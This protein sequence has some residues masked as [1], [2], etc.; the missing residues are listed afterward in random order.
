M[1]PG[2]GSY[3]GAV[4]VHTRLS[5]DG[6]HSIGELK[7]LF[8]NRGFHFAC[9]TDHSQDLSPDQFEALRA[10]CARFSDERFILIPGLE[11]S[12]DGEIHIM[13]IGISSMTTETTPE[14]VIDHIHANNGVAVL[15]HPSKSRR[16]EFRDVWIRKLDGA[17]IW[18]RSVDS[19]LVPE[20]RSIK[21][22]SEFR[23]INPS[24][25]AFFGLD[26]HKERTLADIGIVVAARDLT[27][28]QVVE[29]LRQRQFRC[30]SRFF[31]MTATSSLSLTQM[32]IVRMVKYFFNGL[33]S[34]RLLIQRT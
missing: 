18:N 31:R 30:W 11:Y 8:Q 16:Y 28:E 7:D 26:L 23:L 13:G 4:H 24:I 20:P 22:F 27:C 3:W 10:E 17:E 2:Q 32:R 14:G 33:R 5:H 34:F 15:S 25:G 29:A 1:N 12:C 9:L 21:L 6:V 19:L